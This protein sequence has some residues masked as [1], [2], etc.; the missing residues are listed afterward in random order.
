MLVPTAC[1][2]AMSACG[3]AGYEAREAFEYGYG[4]G[5]PCAAGDA[6]CAEVE[7]HI[8]AIRAEW[9]HWCGTVR[10]AEM[11]LLEAMGE[12]AVPTLLRE[13]DTDSHVHVIVASRVLIEL[14]HTREIVAWCDA[15]SDHDQHDRVC[16]RAP[17]SA[18]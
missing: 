16:R 5:A 3:G 8:S 11:T 10:A 12:R 14:G 1:A 13:L 2:V 4:P 6:D 9:E 18:R 15:N 7:T 17:P